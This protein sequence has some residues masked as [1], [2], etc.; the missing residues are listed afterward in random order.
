MLR[1]QSIMSDPVSLESNEKGMHRSIKE[2]QQKIK[3]LKLKLPKK[4]ELQSVSA[5]EQSARIQKIEK[6]QKLIQDM[7]IKLPEQLNAQLKKFEVEFEKLKKLQEIKGVINKLREVVPQNITDE[8]DKMEKN[9]GLIKHEIADAFETQFRLPALKDMAEKMVNRI[10]SKQFRE[11]V[12]NFRD[13]FIYST[14]DMLN[15][16]IDQLSSISKIGEADEFTGSFADLSEGLKDTLHNLEDQLTTVVSEVLNELN[17]ESKKLEEIDGVDTNL[18][19]FQTLASNMENQRAE[20]VKIINQLETETAKL[21]E[22]KDSKDKKVISLSEQQEKLE[23]QTKLLED[24]KLQLEQDKKQLKFEKTQ[25]ENIKEQ[26]EKDKENLEKDKNQLKK[27]KDDK[28]KQIGKLSIE[29]QKIIEERDEKDEKLG[30]ITVNQQE[31][32]KE[33]EILKEELKKFQNVAA[34]ENFDNLE[35]TDYSF[36]EI[37]NLLKLYMTLI[38]TIWQ[39]SVHTKILNLLHGDREEL[40]RNSIKKATGIAGAVVLRAIHELAKEKLIIYDENTGMVKLT[41][42]LFPKSR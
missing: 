9:L 38:E 33:Y 35:E 20:L 29:Q 13:K 16:V 1:E 41:K 30:L 21:Q 2:M 31:L 22:E 18:E 11:L 15:Q 10:I 4:L 27:E 7:K 34:L 39:G 25:L 28:E 5:E 17:R 14:Q 8:F 36:N 42:R 26:L 19:K 6:Y 32:L 23:I 37:H 3:D 24:E 12:V 40:D